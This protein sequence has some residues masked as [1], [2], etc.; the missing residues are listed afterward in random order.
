[1][2]QNTNPLKAFIIGSTGAVGRELVQELVKSPKW[3]EITLIVRR[4]LEEWDQFT[5]AEKQK[6]KIVLKEDLDCL[7][8]LSQWDLKG[9]SSLFCCLGSRVKEGEEKFM[10]V[11][12]TYPMYAAKLAS[13]F[14]IPHFSFVSGEMA[15][16][17]SWFLLMRAK[18]KTEESLRGF[19][20][21]HL[22]LIRPAAIVNLRNDYRLGEVIVGKIPLIPKIEC[23]DIAIAMRIEAELQHSKPHDLKNIVFHNSDLHYLVKNQKYPEKLS[24]K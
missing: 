18:G 24:D 22:S 15:S 17:T 23:R 4:K 10:K 5:E 3:Q 8:D 20:F 13:H 12:Y 7:D 21:P 9:Y 14:K 1:M 19:N 6:L 11:E 16:P 2:E